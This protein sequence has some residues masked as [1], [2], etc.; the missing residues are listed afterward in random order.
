V[1]VGAHILSLTVF[2]GTVES[3]GGDIKRKRVVKVDERELIMA[4]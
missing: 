3:D 1:R 4:V 2:S